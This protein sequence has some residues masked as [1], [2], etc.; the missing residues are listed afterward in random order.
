[1]KLDKPQKSTTMETIG[2]GLNSLTR[3]QG[4]ITI[5]RKPKETSDRK[6]LRA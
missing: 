1:M 5:T 6:N 3:V 2:R 4:Q